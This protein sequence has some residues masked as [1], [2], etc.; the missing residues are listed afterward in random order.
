MPDFQRADLR[1]SSGDVS[2][3]VLPR[4]AA[5]TA[6]ELAGGGNKRV[7]DD[8]DGDNLSKDRLM[9]VFTDPV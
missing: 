6:G 5:A 2:L 3:E 4:I 1:R 9:T 8:L 7:A